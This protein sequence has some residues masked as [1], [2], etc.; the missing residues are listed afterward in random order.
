MVFGRR[1]S[2]RETQKGKWNTRFTVSHSLLGSQLVDAEEIYPLLF[3]FILSSNP[4]HLLILRSDQTMAAWYRRRYNALPSIGEMI[5]EIQEKILRLDWK[6]TE[7]EKEI[8]EPLR[9][10]KLAE[11]M[12]DHLDR[13]IDLESRHALEVNNTRADLEEQLAE[14]T[15]LLSAPDGRNDAVAPYEGEKQ[16]SDFVQRKRFIRTTSN[17]VLENEKRLRCLRALSSVVQ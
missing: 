10:L 12:M 11:E 7:A 13:W 15:T 17:G 5:D 1:L 8:Q 4:S 6:I 16:I 9:R 3:Y 2:A 14:N